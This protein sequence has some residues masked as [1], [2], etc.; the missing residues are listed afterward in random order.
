LT[1]VSL[2]AQFDL[3]AAEYGLP[4]AEREYQFLKGIRRWRFDYAWP[5]SHVAVEI[6]G[7]TWIGGRHTRGWGY[8]A[9]CEKYNT[10]AL[11]GW[12]LIRLPGPL[13]NPVWVNKVKQAITERGG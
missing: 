3:L 13:I 7:G 10:A 5:E 6:E 12:T 4:P 2:S 1:T 9:D 11:E 8:V